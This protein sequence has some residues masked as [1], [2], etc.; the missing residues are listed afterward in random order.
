MKDLKTNV[1][2]NMFLEE[3]KE[4]YLKYY[5][6]IINQNKKQQEALKTLDNYVNF[7][8]EHEHVVNEA[9]TTAKH[10]KRELLEEINNIKG[11]LDG[12]IKITK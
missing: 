3:V 6:H 10:D 12:L 11:D 8:I 9:V 7:L 1:K 4:D 2:Q 5:D